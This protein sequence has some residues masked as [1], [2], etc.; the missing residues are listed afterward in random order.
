MKI[1]VIG[2]EPLRTFG[3]RYMFT[4]I[5]A[6][7]ELITES[8]D[9][10]SK[11]LESYDAFI[12]SPE[13]FISRPDYFMPRRDR[14]L[15]ISNSSYPE[16]ALYAGESEENI[17]RVVSK[18]LLSLRETSVLCELSLRETE[19][20]RELAH[21]KSYKEIADTLCIS[22][23]TVVTHRKNITQKLGIRSVSGLSLYAMMNGII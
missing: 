3:L 12:I 14:I 22:T 18:F 7:T 20:L 1:G 13:V 4:H 21:G 19:V 5:D 6:S 23:N 9:V 16:Y 15:L 17:E 8:A 2:I 11:T 10:S